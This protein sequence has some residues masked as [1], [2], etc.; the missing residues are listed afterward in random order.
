MPFA[1]FLAKVQRMLICM[2]KS[3]NRTPNLQNYD[4][5]LVRVQSPDLRPLE[6]V[7]KVVSMNPE[8]FTFTSAANH[9][10]SL[11]KPRS[12]RELLAVTSNDNSRG[13]RS[14]IM[15]N[16]TIFTEYYPNWRQISKESKNLVI[17]ERES[18]LEK[19]K[20]TVGSQRKVERNGRR[21]LKVL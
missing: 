16:R 3:E 18:S 4:S 6:A 7:R 2:I 12:K 19:G 15:R 20:R 13:D 5:F 21:L 9:I 17:A 11:V 10:S 14:E 8:A 1:T